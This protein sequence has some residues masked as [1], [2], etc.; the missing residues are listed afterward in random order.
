[1]ILYDTLTEA[2]EACRS[3]ERIVKLDGCYAVMSEREY[4]IWQGQK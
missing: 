3:D 4:Q 2:R 1:M